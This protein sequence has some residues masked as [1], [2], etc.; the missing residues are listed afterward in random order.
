MPA[1]R[2]ARAALRG[3]ARGAAALGAGAGAAAVFSRATPAAAAAEP[4]GPGT[5]T[6]DGVAQGFGRFNGIKTV[7]VYAAS[8]AQIDASYKQAAGEL[9]AALAKQGWRVVNGGG[10][11][12]LMGATTTGAAQAGGIVDCVILDK[13]VGTN[14]HPGLRHVR[15]AVNMPQRKMGLYEEGDAYVA[16]PGGLGTMEEFLEILSWRQLGFHERPLVFVNTNGFYTKLVEFIDEAIAKGFVS[17]KV[18]EAFCVAERPQDAVEFLRNYKPYIID[19][20]DIYRG[21]M[22]KSDWEAA[23]KYDSKQKA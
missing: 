19:K 3:A 20:G 13:F 12:G 10:I 21:D 5:S 9:G 11:T 1:Q 8:S 7:V 18:R 23:Q 14:Q 6:I 16:L 2:W 22:A 15:T 17:A 4:R